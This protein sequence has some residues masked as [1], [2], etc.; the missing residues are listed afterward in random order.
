[1]KNVIKRRAGLRIPKCFHTCIKTLLFLLLIIKAGGFLLLNVAAYDPYPK[2]LNGDSNYILCDG[3]MGY[4]W[5]VNK[6]L[7]TMQKYEAPQYIIAVNVV[8]V[9]NAD[10]GNTTISQVKNISTFL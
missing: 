8:T 4:A 7:L 1:M 9:L 5:Y 6:S 2:C 10:R 3:H